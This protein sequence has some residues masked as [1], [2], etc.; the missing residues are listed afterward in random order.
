MEVRMKHS[1]ML[2]ALGFVGAVSLTVTGAYAQGSDGYAGQPGP[3]AGQQGQNWGQQ[4]SPRQGAGDYQ[5]GS[6]YSQQGPGQQA[7]GQQG[8]GNYP[9][10]SA[11]GQQAPRQQGWGYG[12]QGGEHAQQGAPYSAQRY[13]NPQYGQRYQDREWRGRPSHLDAE[14]DLGLRQ[15]MRMARRAFNEQAARDETVD[16]YDF[17][18]SK[19]WNYFHSVENY[20]D[21]LNRREFLSMVEDMFDEVDRDHDGVLEPQELQT[22]KGQALLDIIG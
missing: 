8:P 12:Q 15:T 18:P 19:V 20:G 21:N 9:Q 11:Y 13:Q 16:K 10:G 3:G 7:S 4:A 22:R 1:L 6:G 17:A 14:E 2:G 5:Q